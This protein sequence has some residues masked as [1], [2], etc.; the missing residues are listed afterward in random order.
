[1]DIPRAALLGLLQGLAEFLPISSSGHL[2]LVE[3]LFGLDVQNQNLL[4]IL[5][6]IGTLL[7]I[8]IVFWKD[9]MAMLRHPIRNHTLV[10]LIIASLPALL[11]KVLSSK[12][13]ADILPIGDPLKYLGEHNLMLGACFLFTGLVL[14]LAQAAG[15]RRERARG[16]ARD[17]GVVQAI[18]MG[19]MQAIGMAP[20]ISRSGSTIF[21]GVAS[22]LTRQK[23]ARFSFMMSVPAIIA[24]F[25]SEGYSE[26]KNG[27]LFAA[28]DWPVIAVGVIVAAVSGYI[29]IRFM[30]KL[31][32]K[33]SLNWFALYVILLGIAVLVMQITGVM[34]AV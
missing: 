25:A 10:L 11:I 8:L 13:L 3:A 26:W 6:H 15:A 34:A 31:V 21:G 7:P 12:V 1:M 23:A 2:N 32:S 5:L 16:P 17:V 9:W 14:L 19:F 29:A 30:L 18:C 22:G 28:A 20:G 4:N 27:A 24:S 33:T